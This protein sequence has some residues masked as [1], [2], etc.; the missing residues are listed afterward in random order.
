MTDQKGSSK[1]NLP[2]E[3]VDQVFPLL[4]TGGPERSG[5]AG[6]GNQTPTAS[7]VIRDVLGWRP[8]P[9]HPKAFA[10]AL[11][12]SFT[13]SEVQGHVEATYVP[14]GFAVQADLGGISGGQASL[15]S[16]A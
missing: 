1:A 2:V 13:L 8:R 5:P 12:A 9:Q 10:A 16:R 3:N 15:F 4:T 14:R 11:Q 6:A 7:A